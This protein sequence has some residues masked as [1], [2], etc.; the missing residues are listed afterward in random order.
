M[1]LN[2]KA[3]PRPLVPRS[4]GKL[5]V[6]VGNKGGPNELLHNDGGDTFSPIIRK[7]PTTPYVNTH[8]VAFGDV[9]NDGDADIFIGNKV[10]SPHPNTP[11]LLSPCFCSPTLLCSA[12]RSPFPPSLL[13]A[14]PPLLGRARMV[15]PTSYI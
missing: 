13:T 9:D 3:V 5:D 7:E 8:A 11:A 6:L 14:P 10:G 1:A 12:L 4:D 2:D 15:P